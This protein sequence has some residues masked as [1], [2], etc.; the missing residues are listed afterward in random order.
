MDPIRYGQKHLYR[1]Y[2]TSSNAPGSS[3]CCEGIAEEP[4]PPETG[5][6]NPGQK[7]ARRDASSESSEASRKGGD[8]SSPESDAGSSEAVFSKL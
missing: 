6:R 7:A 3:S 8:Q 1:C 5:N 2:R 4:R